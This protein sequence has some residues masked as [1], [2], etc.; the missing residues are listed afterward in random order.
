MVLGHEAAGEVAEQGD[1][2]T[3]L[4]VG[5]HVVCSLV[6]SC[7]H[8][9]YCAD[10]RAALC[11]PGAAANNAETLL[12]GD[13]GLS[14]NGEAVHHHLGISGFAEYAVVARETLI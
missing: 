8:C 5:D 10:G 14:D 2:V 3:D 9:H 6:P 12:A 13:Q 11:A 7:G 4:S 1:G